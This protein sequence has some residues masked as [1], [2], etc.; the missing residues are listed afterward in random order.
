MSL[1][2]VVA[3]STLARL[4]LGRRYSAANSS[5]SAKTPSKAAAALTRDRGGR[6]PAVL[7]LVLLR[8]PDDAVA[9]VANSQ[10]TPEIYNAP[11]FDRLLG[12][13]LLSEDTAVVDQQATSVSELESH[14]E[15]VRI[16]PLD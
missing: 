4:R 16:Y 10:P 15:K 7:T 11:A 5:C 6:R 3:S 9:P 8:A 2:A 12:R 13:P 1:Q 14:N